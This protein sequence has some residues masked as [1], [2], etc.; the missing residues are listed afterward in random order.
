M[1]TYVVGTGPMVQRAPWRRDVEVWARGG[2][3]NQC[4]RW[5]WEPAREADESRRTWGR[6]RAGPPRQIAVAVGSSLPARD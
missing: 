6:G 5:G 4:G 1:R 3:V 2:Q